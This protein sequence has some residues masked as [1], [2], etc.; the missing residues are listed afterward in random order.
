MRR[1]RD[2]PTGLKIHGC[3]AMD[4][5][6]SPTFRCPRMPAIGGTGFATVPGRV[7]VHVQCSAA[8]LGPNSGSAGATPRPVP[9]VRGVHRYTCNA[10]WVSARVTPPGGVSC[11]LSSS[12][13]SATSA[14]QY[15]RNGVR[16]PRSHRCSVPRLRLCAA[17]GSCAR[18]SRPTPAAHGEPAGCARCGA[19]GNR[20]AI[21]ARAPTTA[22]AHALSCTKVRRSTSPSPAN[23]AR[24]CSIVSSLAVSMSIT[25]PQGSTPKNPLRRLCGW[26]KPA[27]RLLTAFSQGYTRRLFPDS[28]VGRATDC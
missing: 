27:S 18:A 24:I 7:F 11:R 22:S 2:R 26:T 17:A 23:N 19:A 8:T 10:R 25:M 28:S 20:R 12:A 5:A 13:S 14:S 4:G 3:A 21:A 16:A 6:N 9:D 15:R 1:G